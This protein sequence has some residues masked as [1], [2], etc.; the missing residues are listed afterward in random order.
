MTLDSL[1]FLSAQTKAERGMGGVFYAH[2][3]GQ[4]SEEVSGMTLGEWLSEPSRQ[5][6]LWGF[7]FGQGQPPGPFVAKWN[8]DDQAWSYYGPDVRHNAGPGWEEL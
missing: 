6:G 5:S 3:G 1:R 7:D 2:R 4:K 8:D